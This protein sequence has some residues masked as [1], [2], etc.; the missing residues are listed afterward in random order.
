[1]P[2]AIKIPMIIKKTFSTI[3]NMTDAFKTINYNELLE[4]LKKENQEGELKD[5]EKIN[6]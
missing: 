1:M 4:E 3:K 6:N 2:V 5:D